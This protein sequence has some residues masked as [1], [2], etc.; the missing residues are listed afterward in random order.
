[1]L[2]LRKNVRERLYALPKDERIRIFEQACLTGEQNEIMLRK[3][4]L[5]HSN[6]KIALELNLSVEAVD[7]N[8]AKAYDTIIGVLKNVGTNY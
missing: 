2:T 1:M 5:R 7:K 8:I 6:V 4:V 3:F